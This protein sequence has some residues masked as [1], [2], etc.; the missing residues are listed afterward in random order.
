MRRNSGF[1]DDV[2]ARRSMIG[3]RL[4]GTCRVQSRLIWRTGL[5]T[6]TSQHMENSLTRHVTAWRRSTAPR[7]DR[8]LAPRHVV[9]G[10]QLFTFLLFS[11]QRC[12]ITIIVIIIILHLVL[13]SQRSRKLTKQYKG[14]YDRQS[15]L[16]AAGK[17]S[18]N[19]TTLK[20]KS[21]ELDSW[22]L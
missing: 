3:G 6:L 7:R 15:V 2:V 4:A 17:L 9:S 10:R 5:A 12:I 16:S 8:R 19:E 22:S 14:G 20:Q 1:H 18:C 13:R 11:T 21:F